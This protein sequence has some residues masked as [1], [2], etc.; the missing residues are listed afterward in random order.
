M[1][2]AD[3]DGM[4][5][6]MAANRG[7]RLVKS[8]RR[9]PGGDHGLY[10]LK[11]RESGKH[12][13]GFDGKGLAAT[14]DEIET[15]LRGSAESEW[16]SSVGSFKARKGGNAKAV[17]RPKPKTT[18]KPEPALRIREAA[19]RDSAAIAALVTELGFPAFGE[20]IE[21]RLAAL[22][23]AGEPPLVA[24]AGVLAGC[25]TWHVTPVLHRPQPVGRITML[26]VAQGARRKGIGRAL[27]DAAADRLARS[28]CGLLE[29]T[30]NVA[31]ADA[32]AFYRRLGFER[33]SYRFVKRLGV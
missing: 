30:S 11:D 3:N 25:L 28:G 26:V 32:H 5:R 33:T 1:A 8:R 27:V 12:V 9:R 16:K 2:E 21:K 7:C 18:P 24:E 29:V 15:W 23:R 22:K 13:F 6:E 14:A 17:A 4:L 10:G 31:L 19:T 20:E